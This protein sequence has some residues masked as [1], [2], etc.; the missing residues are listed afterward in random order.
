MLYSYVEIVSHSNVIYFGK[1]CTRLP[2]SWRNP[3]STL[4]TILHQTDS[5]RNHG[6]GML[7]STTANN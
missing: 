7:C 5:G 4:P 3:G 1:S 6:D 2:N